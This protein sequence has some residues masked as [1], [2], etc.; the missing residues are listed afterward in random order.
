MR[1]SGEVTFVTVVTPAGIEEFFRAQ[2]DFLAS[3][4][5]G[6]RPDPALLGAVQGASTRRV[7]GP[8]I[9]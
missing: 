9:R 4:P 2:R 6:T 1:K 5:P 8:P 7:V 3:V